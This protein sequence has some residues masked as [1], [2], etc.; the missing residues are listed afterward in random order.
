MPLCCQ[1]INV[2]NIHSFEQPAVTIQYCTPLL[3][4]SPPWLAIL[5]W[6]EAARQRSRYW[7]RFRSDCRVAANAKATC[8]SLRLRGK[9]SPNA[10]AN[11]EECLFGGPV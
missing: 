10:A 7:Y 5:L 9:G 2:E 11:L 6:H 1:V 3:L 8:P 4:I